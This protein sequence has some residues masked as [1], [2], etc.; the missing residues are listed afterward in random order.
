MKSNTSLTSL[1]LPNLVNAYCSLDFSGNTALTSFSFPKCNPQ[2]YFYDGKYDIQT[3]HTWN[4]CALTEVSVNHILSRLA[5]QVGWVG[6]S[7]VDL[8]GGT[9][10]APTGQGLIDKATLIASGVTVTTN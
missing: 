5:L 10:A 1:S 7:T 4:G 8:A 9:N 6:G 2:P 3:S